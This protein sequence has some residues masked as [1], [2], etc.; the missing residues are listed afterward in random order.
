MT[1][2]PSLDEIG[3]KHGTD[4][5]STGH[6]YL[7]FLEPFFSRMRDK[8]IRLLEIGVH[9]GASL[10]TWAEYFPNAEIVGVD[11]L[12][13]CKRY[14]GG[15]VTVELADQSNIEHLTP[16]G[17]ARG[18]FDIIVE[19]GSHLWEHQVTSL[20]TLFPFLKDGGFYVAEDLQTNY[21]SAAAQ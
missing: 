15:R 14:E 9:R 7:N 11:V 16:I 19:D 12:P 13:W 10:R 2:L 3:L 20:K 4:K 18:P 21:G 5:A 6:D 1:E 17:V 8:P